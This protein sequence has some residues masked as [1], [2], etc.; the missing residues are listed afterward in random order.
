MPKRLAKCT[1]IISSHPSI[2]LWCGRECHRQ[3]RSLGAV[4]ARAQ[5]TRS[6]ISRGGSMVGSIITR[7]SGV[8]RLTVVVGFP[9]PSRMKPLVGVC[10]LE[11]FIIFFLVAGGVLGDIGR[12]NG[13]LVGFR[14][15][16][17]RIWGGF[18]EPRF[19]G[20]RLFLLLLDVI[21][22]DSR[23]GSE[24]EAIQTE[25]SQQLPARRCKKT[26]KMMTPTPMV[27]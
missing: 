18:A 5:C 4:G 3:T 22:G 9:A 7:C 11:Q 27:E 21:H 20:Q 16:W 6:G 10:C 1:T 12:P 2:T 17:S 25:I 15:A 19:G 24:K 13:V 8:V 26:Y 23:S 14:I